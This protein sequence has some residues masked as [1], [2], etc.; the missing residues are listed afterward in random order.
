VFNGEAYLTEAIASARAQGPSLLEIVVV[1]DG[2]TDGTAAVAKSYGAPVRYL[3][4]A[5]AGP[6][7]ARNRGIAEARGE[8]LAFL[9]ADDLWTPER[10]ERQLAPFE[11]DPLVF[12]TVCM[13]QNFWIPELEDEARA[14]R[15]QREGAPA[16]GY[17]T[18]G[19]LARREAFERAGR[20][21]P[22][23]DHGDSM[24]W[25]LRARAAGL[26]EML[27]PEVLVL[28]RM[29]GA[30]RSRVHAAASREEFLHLLKRQLDAR[31]A[32]PGDRIL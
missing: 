1:D 15:L 10:L 3:H 22:S 7:A 32:K 2:S 21:D 28:R 16:P 8:V 26:K 6:A 13:I 30:N 29:H 23:L 17:V 14:K 20:F 31:R 19:L 27:V 11:A 9:D 24:D 12:Y 4:Q 18:G 5:N 25:F